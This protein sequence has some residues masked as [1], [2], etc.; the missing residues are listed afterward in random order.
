MIQSWCQGFFFTHSFHRFRPTVSNYLLRTHSLNKHL[1][2]EFTAFISSTEAERLGFSMTCSEGD[3]W[4]LCGVVT[5]ERE[6]LTACA[7]FHDPQT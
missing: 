4:A 2:L 6:R 3:R 7:G 5:R 1:L